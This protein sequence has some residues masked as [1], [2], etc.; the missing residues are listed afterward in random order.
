MPLESLILYITFFVLCGLAIGAVAQNKYGEAVPLS[1]LGIVLILFSALRDNVGRDYII[2][3]EA[4]R[5]TDYPSY[6][7][8]E[9]IWQRFY[10]LLNYFHLSFYHWTLIVAIIFITL[11]LWALRKQSYTLWIALAFF[12]F[13]F[14]LYFESFNA[15]RQCMAQAIVLFAV[16]LY[17]NRKYW[18]T[19]LILLA[20]IA[21]HR[22]AIIMI[23][24]LPFLFV[25]FNPLF[26][27]TMIVLSLTII[28]LLLKPFL[29]LITPYLPFD[30]YYL[31]NMWATQEDGGSGILYFLNTILSL[32]LIYRSKELYRKDPNI[33][34]YLNSFLFSTI[35]CNS[36]PFFQAGA[37][38]YYY[39]FMFL[40]ILMSN[41]Y[42]I[43]NKYDRALVMGLLFLQLTLTA[44]TI[45]L[46]DESFVRYKIIFKDREKRKT[47]DYRTEV[48]NYS[49]K[50]DQRTALLQ[51][52]GNSYSIV[53]FNAS[54]S[55]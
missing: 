20:A 50:E 8:L 51:C 33:L 7:H 1:F 12:V 43:G 29:I 40:P 34:P 27:G 48:L 39:M 41:L 30:T 28:P 49:G 15:V 46:P 25:R 4:F 5:T 42:T 14:K 6:K 38:L 37:R 2:Y 19:L 53:R 47:Y 36:L 22:S 24:L 32:Y 52:S 26:I 9:W 18:S 21:V 10:D 13:T 54:G 11:V 17:A 35:I 23:V 31:E 55:V 3:E 44:K 45:S 16:P